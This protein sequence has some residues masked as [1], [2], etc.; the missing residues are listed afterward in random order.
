MNRPVY[1]WQHLVLY[2]GFEGIAQEV[3]SSV[4]IR[5]PSNDEPLQQLTLKDRS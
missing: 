1:S 5:F 4:W 3:N 2:L